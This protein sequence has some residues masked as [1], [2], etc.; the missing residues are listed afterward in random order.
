MGVGGVKLLQKA[1]LKRGAYNCYETLRCRGTAI[2]LR[3]R[4]CSMPW[5]DDPDPIC[6]FFR[7]NRS[8]Q[9]SAHAQGRLAGRP[10]QA[11]A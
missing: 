8:T 10:G 2:V 6:K 9:G 3:T 11:A 5:K 4:P 7:R 1:A